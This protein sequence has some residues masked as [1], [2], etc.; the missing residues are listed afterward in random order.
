VEISRQPVGEALELRV[1][2]R[3]DAYWAD[4]LSTALAEAVR[5]GAY[6]IRLN[7]ADVSYMSSVGI[8]VLVRV[9][10][11]LQQLKGSFVVTAPSP[12]VKA[13]L[14]LAGLGLLM[15]EAAPSAPPAPAAANRTLERAGAAFEISDVAPGATLRCRVVGSPE[16]LPAGRFRQEDCTVLRFPP[17]TFGLGLGAFG[18]DFAEARRRCGEFLCAAGAAACLPTDGT[19]VPDYFT[20]AGALVPE[21]TVLYALACE[22]AFAS[23]AR[24]ATQAG[25]APLRLSE[26]TAACLD[27]VTADTVGIVAVAESAGLLGAALRRPPVVEQAETNLF[28]HPGVRDWLSF[29]PERSFLRSL[30]LVVGVVAR[31]APPTLAPLL[32]P[33]RDPAGPVGHFHAAAF[34]YRP[35]QRG[36]VELHPTVAGLFEGESLLGV[37][38]LLHDDR[39]IVGAGES[40][41]VRGACWVGPINDI[42]TE[43]T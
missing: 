7:M 41:F 32:R 9:Y 28:V 39:E 16:P 25:A 5:D 3:L 33:L 31:N 23:V 21:L 30:A 2:G 18:R 24:F 43:E 15:A 36:V 35:I 6:N 17:P 10:K 34:S 26:L 42:G 20:S 1:S 40:A 11:H 29:T 13:V 22:G 12:A 27:L 38:H 8:R 19:D 37:L 14:D 4:H